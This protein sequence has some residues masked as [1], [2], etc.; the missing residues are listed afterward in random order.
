MAYCK[1]GKKVKASKIKD[2]TYKQGHLSINQDNLLIQC[3]D[4]SVLFDPSDAAT[5]WFIHVENDAIEDMVKCFDD[6]KF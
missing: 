4:S 1:E 5:G 3:F 6:V 2:V